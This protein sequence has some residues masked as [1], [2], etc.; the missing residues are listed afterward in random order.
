[1]EIFIDSGVVTID[2]VISWH[3]PKEGCCV[4]ERE[5][6]WMIRGLDD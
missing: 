5:D 2:E 6:D 3:G 1:M 4:R